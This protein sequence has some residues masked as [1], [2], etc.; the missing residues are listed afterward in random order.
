MITRQFIKL[1]VL[2]LLFV[3]AESR[4]QSSTQL[5]IDILEAESFISIAGKKV[6]LLSNSSGRN[7][8]GQSTLEIL[9]KSSKFEFMGVLAPEHGYYAAVPAGQTV[10]EE[11]IEGIKI[12]SLY[13]STKEPD[14]GLLRQAD[15]VLVDIQDIGVR[16]YTYISSLHRT[17]KAVA[18]S[19][20][21]II[22]LDRPNPIGGMIV[23]GNVLEK[24]ME[25]FVGVVQI[26]YIHGLTI[27]ELA[28]MINEEGWLG[29]DIDGANLKC[30]LKIFKMSG[31]QRWMSWEDTGLMWFPTSPH[32]P[33]VDAVRGL[34][35]VGI[36]GEIGFISIGIGSTS[37]FQYVGNLNF[38]SKLVLKKLE[39][40]NLPGLHF[41]SSRFQPFYG[42]YANRSVESIMLRFPLS[43]EFRPYTWGLKLILAIRAIHP[44]LF[45]SDTKRA[46]IDMFQKVTGTK[47]L[48]EGLFY[49]KTDEYVLEIANRGLNDF[50]LLRNKYLLY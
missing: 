48:Y 13:G 35:C 43:N 2:I 46:G 10:S 41:S 16:S 17:M 37:P 18:Q 40:D 22:I 9:S 32:V 14:K 30:D 44:E 45:K 33:T 27:G 38:N 3:V 20:K 29:K 15:V 11:T 49:N 36:F 31:W 28:L 12:Y 23:D 6:L 8:E 19:G 1:M 26:P 25:S 7:S 47:D 21:Q 42:M 5:G 34:A 50:L 4:A 24:G 39:I